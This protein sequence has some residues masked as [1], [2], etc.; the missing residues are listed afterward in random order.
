MNKKYLK[1]TKFLNKK[2]FLVSIFFLS[3]KLY[4]QTVEFSGIVKDEENKNIEYY[5]GE[6]LS[7]KD[8]AL[9]Y[10]GNFIDGNFMF[11]KIAAGDYIFKISSL[12][13]KSFFE[14][15]GM[16]VEITNK[17]RGGKSLYLV[18]VGD[19]RTTDEAKAAAKDIK[20]KNKIDSIVVERY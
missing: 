17:V 5:T 12:G 16:V 7:I 8:S 3:T 18:W 11:Q 20:K 15:L 14:N 9:I 13:Y 19:Y 2:L 1:N 6:L 10:G 4:S